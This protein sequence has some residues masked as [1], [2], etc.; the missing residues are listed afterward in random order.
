LARELLTACRT[1]FIHSIER[2]LHESAAHLNAL[3][4]RLHSLSP[5][6]VLDRGY[7]LVLDANGGVVRSTLQ[8]TAGDKLVTRLSDGTFISRV[9]SAAPNK[10]AKK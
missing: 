2:R 5:L 3:N 4:A 6:A 1:R 9:E 7:A 10:P 8:I